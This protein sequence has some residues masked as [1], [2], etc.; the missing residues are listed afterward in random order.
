MS[1]SWN[2]GV[3]LALE[4][5]GK[6]T[7]ISTIQEASWALIEDWPLED[8]EAL[9]KALLVIEAAMSGKKTPEEARFAFIAAAHEAG[10]EIQE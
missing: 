1:K 2:K 3:T 10:I 9:D 4:G 6:F 5:P 8:G 7:T